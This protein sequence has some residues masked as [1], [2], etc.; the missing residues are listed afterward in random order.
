MAC[1]PLNVTL[2]EGVDYEVDL[3]NGRIRFLSTGQMAA[4]VA[5]D[6][7]CGATVQ[8]CCGNQDCG[9]AL[10]YACD[11]ACYVHD[12]YETV[13]QQ[14]A[15]DYRSDDEKMVKMIAVEAEPLPQ[16]TPSVIRA[17]V[18]YAATPS[19]FTWKPT[20]SLNYECQTDRSAAQHVAQKTRPDGTFYFPTW[21]RGRFLASRFIIDGIGGGGKFSGMSFMIKN[22]GQ[23]DSP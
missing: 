21:R 4:L 5:S 7:F 23:Q 8:F 22:W 16:S 20:K 19:C 15:E 17:E 11:R 12:G 13:L 14:G 1:I 9:T 2:V 10:P 6:T 18:G 3:T